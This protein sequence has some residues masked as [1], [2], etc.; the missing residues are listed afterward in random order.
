MC[1]LTRSR[2][3]GCPRR[4]RLL[5]LPRLPPLSGC[6]AEPLLWSP[7]AKW[8]KSGLPNN[9]RFD[10]FPG[11]RNT[12]SHPCPHCPLPTAIGHLSHPSH[13]SHFSFSPLGAPFRVFRGPVSGFR[14]QVSALSLQLSPHFCFLLFPVL[15]SQF[16]PFPSCRV[17]RLRLME[18]A[19]GILA[20][21]SLSLVSGQLSRFHIL[22]TGFAPSCSS[23][24]RFM[25]KAPAN[26]EA[27][28][29]RALGKQESASEL[30]AYAGF[31]RV[32]PRSE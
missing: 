31:D 5:T 24:P 32:N 26:G 7:I 6:R 3:S 15:L 17:L 8:V 14:S 27:V 18:S 20:S 19:Q 9:L 30:G 21:I 23:A 13:T 2:R 10:P 25:P 16:Q 12:A 28:K 22:L 11:H 29:M 1:Q 4:L